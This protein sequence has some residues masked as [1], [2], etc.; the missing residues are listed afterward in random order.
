MG[1]PRDSNSYRSWR[2]QS[3]HPPQD[4]SRRRGPIDAA[5]PLVALLDS[6][7]VAA[8]E[9]KEDPDGL[10]SKCRTARQRQSLLCDLRSG[11][12]EARFNVRERGW[13]DWQRCS[14]P[15]NRKTAVIEPTR[16]L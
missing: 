16:G 13:I 8:S 4:L 7:E 10:L 15:S 11:T 12:G 3:T 14:H 1:D 6:N 5:I 2:E 9:G